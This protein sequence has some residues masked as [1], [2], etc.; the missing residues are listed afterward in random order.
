VDVTIVA[1]APGEHHDSR[2][3][4]HERRSAFSSSHR[5]ELI[6]IEAVEKA[7]AGP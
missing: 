1:H 6:R 4:F 3:L 2:S 7:L 5:H